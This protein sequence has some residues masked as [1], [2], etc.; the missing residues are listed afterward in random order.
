[1]LLILSALG[2]LVTRVAVAASLMLFCALNIQ[3]THGTIELHD[4]GSGKD[5]AA[6]GG[7]GRA[8]F[9]RRRD[10]A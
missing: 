10:D 5:D 6:N 7:A 2:K 1:M 3:Q 8:E 9:Q 4:H